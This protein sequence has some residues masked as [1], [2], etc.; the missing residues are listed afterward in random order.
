MLLQKTLLEATMK[1][2]PAVKNLPL[3]KMK[4]P[5]NAFV[6]SHRCQLDRNIKYC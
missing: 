1:S 5:V 4:H 3:K 6:G 2:V